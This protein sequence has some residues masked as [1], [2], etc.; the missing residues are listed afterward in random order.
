[1][2]ELKLNN[3]TLMDALKSYSEI[4]GVNLYDE[5]IILLLDEIQYEKQWDLILK[6]L[7]DTTNIFVIATGS[8]AVK[9]KESP[10]LAR[11]TL[12]KPIY[13][14]TFREYIYLTH[15]IKIESI[16]EEV[17]LNGKLDNFKKL[18]ARVYSQITEDEVKKYLRIG[19]LPLH[20]KG[21]NWMFMKKYI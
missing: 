7:Y 5:K 10:D 16:F 2:N 1:M 12:H 17:I 18:Y 20:W 6:N 15:N 11:K 19:S 14:M 4:F 9:L 8:S 21:M 13:P 3:I